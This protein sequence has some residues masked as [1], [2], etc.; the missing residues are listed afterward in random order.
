MAKKKSI[1]EKYWDMMN[2]KQ[3]REEYEAYLKEEERHP[4][5]DSGRTKGTLAKY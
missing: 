1:N 3:I 4:G 5:P 2:M